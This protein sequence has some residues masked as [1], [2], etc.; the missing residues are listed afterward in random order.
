MRVS[1][2]SLS[3]RSGDEIAVTFEISNGADSQR[4]ILIL[5]TRLVADLRL[6][7]G[8]VDRETFDSVS[9]NADVYRAVKRGLNILGY[10]SC[11][12]RALCRKLVS[13]GVSREIAEEAVRQLTADGYLDPEGDALREAERCVGKHWGRR[14]ITAALYEKGYS[15]GAVRASL[16]WLEDSGVDFAA[17]CAERLENTVDELPDDVTQRRKL[18]ASLERY[19][20]SHAEIREAFEIFSENKKQFT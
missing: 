5:P 15:D 14:R 16:L 12:E 11:S 1:V 19:G 9:Y 20:F 8:E 3:A 4:E 18:I 2:L 17:L 6:T 10:G 7:V 13:K